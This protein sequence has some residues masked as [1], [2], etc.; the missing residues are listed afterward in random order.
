MTLYRHIVVSLTILLLTACASL[1]QEPTTFV[2][3]PD[4]VWQ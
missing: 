3:D 1:R 2:I 4:L